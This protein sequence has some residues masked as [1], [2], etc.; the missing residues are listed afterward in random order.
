MVCHSREFVLEV[1]REKKLSG[2]VSA[3]FLEQVMALSG[4]EFARL[5]RALDQ[6]EEPGTKQR[7][8][9]ARDFNGELTGYG[10][11]HWLQQD[12]AR[13]NLARAIGADPN[14]S[15]DELIAHAADAVLAGKRDIGYA[16][17]ALRNRL[18][19]KGT[20]Q[21]LIYE[22]S[23]AGRVYL[24]LSNHVDAGSDEEKSLALLL[25]VQASLPPIEF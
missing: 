8:K 6:L 16:S 19:G 10:H 21:W 23:E 20:G 3:L 1:L 14:A 9:A 4:D 2:R 12:W 24:C 7:N 18:A 5:S 22:S 11:Y 13:G 25:E 15:M 17:K